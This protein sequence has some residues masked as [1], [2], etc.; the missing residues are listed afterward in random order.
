MVSGKGEYNVHYMRTKKRKDKKKN[1]NERTKEQRKR[2]N[3]FRSKWRKI[4]NWNWTKQ[5]VKQCSSLHMMPSRTWMPT[6]QS[7]FDVSL[8]R[9]PRH[10][11]HHIYF[12]LIE[13]GTTPTNETFFG[14]SLIIYQFIIII[15]SFISIYGIWSTLLPYTFWIL[16][17]MW[18]FILTILTKIDN[19]VAEIFIIFFFQL[20]SPIR[21][22]I[23]SWCALVLSLKWRWIRVSSFFLFFVVVAKR[24]FILWPCV[25]TA[26]TRNGI[27]SIPFSS[28]SMS[29]HKIKMKIYGCQGAEFVPASETLTTLLT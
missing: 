4:T 28:L 16:W 1:E 5:R 26:R 7:T 27:C 9:K 20:F 2:R 14:W 19:F 25:I 23:V 6:F 22:T 8:H 29:L 3:G 12:F 11:Q 15:L 17:K 24:T 18:T 10:F 13:S 21:T